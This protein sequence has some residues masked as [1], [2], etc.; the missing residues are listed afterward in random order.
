MQRRFAV[1]LLAASAL[2]AGAGAAQAQ[3]K[4]G[5]T[6]ST[7]GPAASLGVPQRNSLALLPPEI[8]GQ[9]VE[10]IVLDDGT[11]STKAV[12]TPAS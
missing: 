3:V 1:M 6:I 4:I 5:V 12:A 8:A 11:D 9:K 2:A 10:Y 7:T